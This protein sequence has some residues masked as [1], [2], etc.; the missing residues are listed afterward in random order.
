MSI[1]WGR[2]EREAFVREVMRDAM[3]ERAELEARAAA[4]RDALRAVMNQLEEHDAGLNAGLDMVPEVEGTREDEWTAADRAE[5][6]ELMQ[7]DDELNQAAEE[8]YWER[9]F[10]E[11]EEQRNDH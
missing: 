2:S 3:A 5:Y 10:A 11:E 6:N 8:A 7:R 4:E 9:R 1:T